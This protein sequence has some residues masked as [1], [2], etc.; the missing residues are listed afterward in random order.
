MVDELAQKLNGR[1]CTKRLQRWHVQVI[2]KD[3]AFL[4]HWRPKHSLSSLV[5]PGHDDILG[6]QQNKEHLMNND[7]IFVNDNCF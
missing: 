3:D 2:N 4:S 7:L 6:I 1:L 5:Q